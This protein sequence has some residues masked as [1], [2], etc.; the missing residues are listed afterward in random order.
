MNE[1]PQIAQSDEMIDA[2]FLEVAVPNLQI[3]KYYKYDPENAMW[4]ESVQY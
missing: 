2:E 3:E 1:D 4:G